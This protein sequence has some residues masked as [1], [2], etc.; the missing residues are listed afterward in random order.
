MTKIE[1]IKELT[2]RL[3]SL[4]QNE[5]DKSTSYYSEIIDDRVEDGMTEEDAVK[6]LGD[7]DLIVTNA[8]YEISLP[9]L[10]KARVNASRS[11]MSNKGLWITLVVLG[12]PLWFPLLMTFLAVI[13]VIYVTIW[14][15]IL[16]LYAVVLA[17]GISGIAGIIGGIVLCF[18]KSLPVGLCTIGAA[19]CC[20]ALTL[21]ITL[22]VLAFTKGLIRF[23]A[24]IARKIKSIFI[25]KKAV[26]V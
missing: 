22:P 6:A 10:M 23:T 11:K 3:A 9:V 14:I 8:M 16:S 21:L 26:T 2:F 13:L 24:W 18:I 5:I 4:P 19:L 15:L 1:F 17:L 12:F 7:M 20:C 25:S